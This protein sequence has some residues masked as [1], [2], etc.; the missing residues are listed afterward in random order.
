MSDEKQVPEYVG[1]WLRVVAFVVD[2][3]VVLLIMAP[4]LFA[5]FGTDYLTLA[6]AGKTTLVD[7]LLQLALLVV[8]MALLKFRG[9]TPG[10]MAVSARVVDAKSLGPLSSGQAVGRYL[11]YFV[12]MLPLMLGFI[13]I[14]FDKRKQGWH[15]KLADTVVIRDRKSN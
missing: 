11:A 1:F 10:K 4:V 13:W 15:D 5:V 6:M 8:A 3:I 2:S 9:A 12:S 14:A 7:S